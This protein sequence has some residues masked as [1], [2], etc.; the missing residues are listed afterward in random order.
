[1]QISKYWFYWELEIRIVTE[2]GSLFIFFPLGIEIDR[3]Y[4]LTFGGKKE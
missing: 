4:N 1:M 2:V 3:I